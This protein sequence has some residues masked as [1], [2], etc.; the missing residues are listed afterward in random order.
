MNDIEKKREALI[1]VYPGP[2]W[3][4]KVIAMSESQV[5][6]VYMRLK[7]QGKVQ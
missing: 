4:R 7:A 5:I 1:A 6:A 2:K 3:H